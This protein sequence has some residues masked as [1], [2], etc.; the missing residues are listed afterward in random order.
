VEEL[1]SPESE[2]LATRIATAGDND[3]VNVLIS[4]V[5][6][7]VQLA[8]GDEVCLAIDDVDRLDDGDQRRLADLIHLL[9]DGCSIR[10]SFTTWTAT[11]RNQADAL[12]EAGASPVTLKG[13]DEDAIE[14]WLES[15]HLPRE[16][17]GD[18]RRATAGYGLH[19]SD[20]IELLRQ[21]RDLATSD[22]ERVVVSRTST[23]WRE[24]DLHTQTSAAKLAAF[25]DPLAIGEVTEYLHLEAPD[26]VVL[27]RRLSDAGFF[28][29][30]PPWFH[31]LRRRC[32]WNQLFH[33]ER[34]AAIAE[35]AAE[36][37]ARLL[38]ESGARFELVAQFAQVIKAAPQLFEA[39][40]QL[41]QVAAADSDEL[42]VAAAILELTEPPDTPALVADV[43]LLHARAVFGVTGNL[44]EALDRLAERELIYVAGNEFATAIVSKITSF[45]AVLLLMSRSAS[46]LGRMSLPR[47]A[48]WLFQRVVRPRL[49]SFLSGEYGVGTP[50]I[51]D[52]GE[53]GARLQRRPNAQGVVMM[54]RKGPNLLLRARYGDLPIY[55]VVAYDL[56]QERDNA[57]QRLREA[58]DLVG[59][60]RFEVAEV[61]EQPQTAVPSRRFVRAVELL[62]EESLGSPFGGSFN[63]RLHQPIGPE[64][65]LTQRTALLEVVRE[66]STPLERLAYELELSVGYAVAIDE[67]GIET[68]QV[69][70]RKGVARFSYKDLPPFESRLHRVE[71]SRLLGLQPREYLRRMTRR[72]GRTNTTDEDPVVAELDDLVGR[73]RGFNASQLHR[74]VVLEKDALETELTAA[75]QAEAVDAIALTSQLGL[76]SAVWAEEGVTTLA[77]LQLGEPDPKLVPGVESS[78]TSVRI[79]NGEGIHRVRVNILPPGEE[80]SP[81]GFDEEREALSAIF[82]EDLSLATF[83]SGGQAD[84]AIAK[85]LGHGPDEIWLSRVD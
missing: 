18:V 58:D 10:A 32:I 64:E 55:A 53:L 79:V 13:L 47:T 82:D 27:E 45:Y 70:G 22:L 80:W 48:S 39:D 62:L 23:A 35:E 73:A 75:A 85:L 42:A 3:V 57:A 67:L 7:V 14:E 76:G 11:S 38:Q 63:R 40:S 17:A 60:L 72:L 84:Y 36:V 8:D 4:Y 46:E 41:A 37:L 78:L 19:V 54:G 50:S 43:V 30:E 9:P 51:A 71:L 12:V 6:D 44:G 68:V 15:T 26:W 56:A 28:V 1:S 66:R 61:F 77:L 5:G 59:D 20:A 49:G 21:G 25:S 52:L 74:Q 24:L 83:L 31:E 29:G 16:L 65:S 33:E 2:R 69:S 34:R 81:R